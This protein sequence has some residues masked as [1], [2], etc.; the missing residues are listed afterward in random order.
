MS[1]IRIDKHVNKRNIE[2]FRAM[3][4][5]HPGEMRHTCVLCGAKTS[6]DMSMSARRQ[7]DMHGMRT[8]PIRRGLHASD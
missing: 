3:G 1:E 4:I 5:S 8:D 2:I 6:I 7:A